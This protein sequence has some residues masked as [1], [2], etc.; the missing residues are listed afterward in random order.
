CGGTHGHKGC[1][2]AFTALSMALLKTPVA[3]IGF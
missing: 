1:E 3:K 2:A